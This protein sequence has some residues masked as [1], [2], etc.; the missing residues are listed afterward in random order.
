[1]SDG[2]THGMPTSFNAPR[3]CDHIWEPVSLSF[4]TE[5]YEVDGRYIRNHIRQ[6]D[7]DEGRCW[8]ICR[9]CA[10]HTYMTTQ[11]VGFRMYGS[12][13]AAVTWEGDDPIPANNKRI[14]SAMQR[15]SWTLSPDEDDEE[16]R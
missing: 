11:Y 15:E 4:E 3:D 7:L 9:R 2:Y 14:T 5:L 1:M 6:P 16:S 10:C 8:F 13:D 12:E